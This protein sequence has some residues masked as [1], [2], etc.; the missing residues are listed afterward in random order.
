MTASVRVAKEL[1]DLQKKPPPYLRNLSSDDANVL[2]WHALLLPDEP[3][4]HLKAFSLCI[5]F[6]QEYPFKPPM[7]KFTTKIYHPN[8]DENGQVCLPIISNE[9]WK[10]CTKTCQVLEALSVL[11]NRPNI[12]EPL[13][14]DLADLLTQN[15]ELFRKNAEEFTLQFGVDRPS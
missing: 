13:R 7:I 10:P 11:V 12:K 4:Y 9:N 14:M 1:E 2:V 5:S 3:P 8:V 15:P 6:P